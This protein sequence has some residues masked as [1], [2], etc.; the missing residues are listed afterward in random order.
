MGINY[1]DLLSMA[2]VTYHVLYV[3]KQEWSHEGAW[4]VHKA[5]AL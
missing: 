4:T 2:Y 5:P 1:E 3:Y